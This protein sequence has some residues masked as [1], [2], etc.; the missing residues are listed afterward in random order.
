MKKQIEK[1]T[2]IGSG[3]I[4]T[5]WALN[6][7]WKNRKV[8]IYDITDT[9]L[10]AARRT[11]N[12]N[13]QTLKDYQVITDS[14]ADKI[15]SRISFTTDMAAALTDTQ[16][17][18]ESGPEN[19]DIKRQII[20]QIEANTEPDTVIA[21]S[22]SGLLITK[23][24]KNAE[25]PERIIG[26]HPYNPP[27]LIPLVEIVKGEKSSSEAVQTAYDFYQDLGKEPVV[28]NK[29]VS[30]FI[31]NRLQVAVYR[32]IIDL[33]T[34]GVCSLED[35]DK[36]LLWG[37]G[38]RWGV[39]GPSLIFHLGAGQAGLG[40]MLEKQRASFNLR[41]SEMADW[42][43][44]PQSYIDQADAGI[45]EEIAHLPEQMGKTIPELAQCRDSMLIQLLRLHQKL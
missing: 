26:G 33:V 35:T 44:M 12:T 41:L 38:L 2:C 37:P 14:D 31:S 29:E 39:M 34:N 17:A 36:A 1:V 6:F 25:H 15:L 28:L 16:F 20:A 27:H 32:E 42:K 11:L 13:L 8:S 23:I 43:E 3:V 18:Q 5:S 21:T 9:Q 40:V 22:T 19:Y 30:G 7:A 45:A 4:G 10:D 24:A